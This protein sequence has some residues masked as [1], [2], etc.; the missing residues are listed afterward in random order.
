VASS[1]TKI[2]VET[3]T[4]AVAIAALADEWRRLE[5]QTPEASGFQNFDWCSPW[6]EA[7]AAHGDRRSFRIL[8]LRENGRLVML[9]PL[10]LD[11]LFGV[12]VARWLGEPMTQYGD[13]LA[14]PGR[15]RIGWLKAAQEE[16]S[17]WRDVDLFALQRMRADGVL[18]DAGLS[19]TAY[20]ETLAAPFVDLRSPSKKGT[21][22]SAAR[23]A[24]RLATLGELRLEEADAPQERLEIMR[25]ALALKRDWL[26]AKGFISAGLSDPVTATFLERLAHDGAL[27][28]HALKIGEDT[29]AIDIGFVSRDAYRSLLGAYDPRFAQGAPGHALSARLIAYFRREGCATYDFLAPADPYKLAFADGE[30]KLFAYFN[31]RGP[32]G[33]VAGFALK[34]LRPAAKRLLAKRAQYRRPQTEKPPRI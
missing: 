7:A 8:C 5:L 3:A 28:L 29:G 24:R 21:G 30:I 19:A 12:K 26:R 20:G 2:C 31:A 15:E 16:M 33:R 4:T 9:W 17:G 18:A 14:L 13:A 22:K 6:M 25:R 1:L 32:A 23:R 34:W 11:R 27:R 10:Q